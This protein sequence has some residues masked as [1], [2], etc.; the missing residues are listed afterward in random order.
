MVLLGISI[1]ILGISLLVVIELLT[2]VILTVN[3]APVLKVPKVTAP[4]L[5]DIGILTTCVVPKLPVEE[6]LVLAV[7]TAFAVG[8]P[9]IVPVDPLLET[10]AIPIVIVDTAP[11]VK[12]PIE[13]EL[14]LPDIL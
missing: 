14:L 2:P 12:V 4:E 7:N 6:L 1:P 13:P 9:E 5:P 8:I 11:A 3:T 10:P